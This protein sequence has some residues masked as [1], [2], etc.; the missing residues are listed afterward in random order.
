LNPLSVLGQIEGGI[1]QGLGLAVMEEIIQI[2]GI[3]RNGNFTAYLLPTF[4]DMPDVVATLIEE[5]DPHAPLRAKGVGEAPCISSTPAIVNAIRDALR[6]VD[7]VGRPL[8][9]VPVRPGDICL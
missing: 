4:L 8:D 9:R 5:P 6:Q 3:I 7:G 1:A 2:D